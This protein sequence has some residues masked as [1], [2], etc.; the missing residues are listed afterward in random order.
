MQQDFQNWWSFM[1]FDGPFTKRLQREVMSCIGPTEKT[2]I[3]KTNEQTKSQKAFGHTGLTV[4]AQRSYFPTCNYICLSNVWYHPP[5]EFWLDI[6][7]HGSVCPHSCASWPH[8]CSQRAKTQH[9]C[10]F[11][12]K[13]WDQL[14]WKCRLLLWCELVLTVGFNVHIVTVWTLC[15][16]L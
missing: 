5:S 13:A 2:G 15:S 6:R 3:K 7:H 16:F 10:F 9:C 1:A 14:F 4:C 8:A 12:C 11:H